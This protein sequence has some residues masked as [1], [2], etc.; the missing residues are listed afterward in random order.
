MCSVPGYCGICPSP[1]T[2]YM[3]YDMP[4]SGVLWYMSVSGVLWPVPEYCGICPSPVTVNGSGV[5]WYMS[6]PSYRVYGLWCGRFPGSR[7]ICP[8]PGVPL[9]YVRFPGVVSVPGHRVCIMICSVSRRGICPR[10]PCVCYDVLCYGDH[11]SVPYACLWF[12]LFMIWK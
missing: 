1:A 11:I 10:V 8:V 9:W 6:V 5:L 3:E 4:V 12:A 2:V 7:G